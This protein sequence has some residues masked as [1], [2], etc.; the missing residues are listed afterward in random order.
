MLTLSN[1]AIKVN[2]TRKEKASVNYR[3]S[4]TLR[5]IVILIKKINK[6]LDEYNTPQ[7]IVAYPTT[8]MEELLSIMN[9]FQLSC[10]PI[11]KNPWDKKH[12]GM[13]KL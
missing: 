10:V 13:I 7:R 12:I 2:F 3:P 8:N 1:I 5:L 4:K 11:A 9:F 6:K